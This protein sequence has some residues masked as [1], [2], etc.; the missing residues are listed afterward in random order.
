MRYLRFPLRFC[1][2]LSTPGTWSHV[3]GCFPTFLGNVDK[4]PATQRHIPADLNPQSGHPCPPINRPHVKISEGNLE[5]NRDRVWLLPVW[6]WIVSTHN[7]STKRV[8]NIQ[9][10]KSI[11]SPIACQYTCF[12]VS[13]QQSDQPE[14]ERGDIGYQEMLSPSHLSHPCGSYLYVISVFSAAERPRWW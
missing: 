9:H 12:H 14:P 3:P 8:S 4:L 1:W 6:P 2:R 7:Q 11:W 10:K 13:T 5:A